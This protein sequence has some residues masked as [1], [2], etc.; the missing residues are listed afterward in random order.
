[1]QC[2]KS[3]AEE[4]EPPSPSFSQ[5][6][7]FQSRFQ[8]WHLLHY[9]S[10]RGWQLMTELQNCTE[11]SLQQPWAGRVT[12]RTAS[13][14]LSPPLLLPFLCPYAGN[15][16]VCVMHSKDWWNRE[17]AALWKLCRRAENICIPFITIAQAPGRIPA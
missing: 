7:G 8:P 10:A 6:W 9:S 1:M 12:R 16:A 3:V 11:G 2:K 5:V 17:D 14:C 15:F 4:A 13:S